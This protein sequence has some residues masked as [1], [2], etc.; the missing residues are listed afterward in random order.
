MKRR[1]LCLGEREPVPPLI[2]CPLRTRT[3][4]PACPR[5]ARSLA[6]KALVMVAEPAE[7]P[8]NDHDP[9]RPSRQD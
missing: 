6:V 5:A 8:S 1:P 4:S 9:A 3:G 2:S 7:E